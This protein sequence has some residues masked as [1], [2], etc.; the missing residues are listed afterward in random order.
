MHPWRFELEEGWEAHFADYE[1]VQEVA[2]FGRGPVPAQLSGVNL[3]LKW[4][5][6][7]IDEIKI[8]GL[9]W[10]RNGL[11]MV[12]AGRDLMRMELGHWASM[13]HPAKLLE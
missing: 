8:G 2:Q 9:L 7:V 1:I 5:Y 10:K 4:P 6:G 3:G 11:A 12:V 13:E